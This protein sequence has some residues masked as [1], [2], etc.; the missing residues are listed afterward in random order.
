MYAQS[1]M[2]S[3]HVCATQWH[4]DV[5]HVQSC[6]HARVMFVCH[7]VAHT[8]REGM[9]DCTYTVD[10]LYEHD[11]KVSELSEAQVELQMFET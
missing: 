8:Q 3:L 10:T 1:P 2:P 7:W 5:T 11:I 4:T 9:G 6:D